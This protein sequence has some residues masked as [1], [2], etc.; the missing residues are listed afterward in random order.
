MTSLN[1]AGKRRR[2]EHATSTLSKPFKSPLR[3]SV[4]ASETK[5]ENAEDK[6]SSATAAPRSAT[7]E[8]DEPNTPGLTSTPLPSTTT[9]PT[10]TP[11][12]TSQTRKRKTNTSS[13]ITPTKSPLFTDPLVADLQKQQRTL[14]SRLASLRT[15]L[16][17]AQQALRIETSNRDIEL[18]ALITKWR[19]V[20]QDAAEE[21]FA[22]AQERVARM[23]GMAAWR[24][25]MRS[26]QERWEKEEMED[27]YGNVEA[28][29]VDL[30]E[31]EVVSR[32]EEMMEQLGG[33]SKAKEGA[34][35]GEEKG[36]ENEV[37]LHNPISENEGRC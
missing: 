28:E 4:Q 37:C 18:E 7:N 21:V 10:T 20:S 5:N 15:D 33:D 19:A 24:E 31:E 29:G 13:A 27:W 30:D 26:Q 12:L 2:L 36:D 23:G 1:S 14:Q 17:T 16:D 8:K 35:K 9:T 32:R 11:R 6:E 34:K 3:R 22:G 25:Q